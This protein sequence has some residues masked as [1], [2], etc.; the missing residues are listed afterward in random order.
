MF[1]TRLLLVEDHI[2]IR[3]GLKA[4]LATDD[5]IEVIGEADNGREA[6]QKVAELEPD[7]VLM[8]ISM[9]G[10]NGIEATRQMQESH[11]QTRV[12]ILSMHAAPEYVFQVLEAGASAH[13]LKQ[14]DSGEVLTAIQ[15]VLS[16][17]TF[18]SPAISREQIEEYARQ[19]QARREE[20]AIDPL[21]S[22]EREV[23]QLLAE[24]LSNQA[25]ANQLHISVKTV[26][27][28]RSNM[29]RKL[30]ASNKIE[31]IKYALRKGWASL[32]A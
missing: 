23:L 19:V 21:T 9:P 8:D 13:V 1:K 6:L 4:L 5:S 20:E 7:I 14:S 2:V 22:R 16:G 29:M 18:L 24:G 26:E 17:G 28:H 3:Q 15:T 32:E 11:P 10:L 27:T 25:I 31:L 12:V 30:H